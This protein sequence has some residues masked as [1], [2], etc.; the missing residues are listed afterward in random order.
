VK[1]IKDPKQIKILKK[2]QKNTYAVFVL[3][4]KMLLKEKISIDMLQ[5]VLAIDSKP[6]QSKF[7][8]LTS[9]LLRL[10]VILRT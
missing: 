4:E 3:Q 8:A 9:W 2:R 6:L 1:E 7:L 10:M 5:R